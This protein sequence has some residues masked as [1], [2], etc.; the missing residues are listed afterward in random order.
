MRRLIDFGVL[1]LCAAI[2]AGCATSNET[3]GRVFA[4][5]A[6]FQ[7]YDCAQLR[8]FV[9]GGENNLRQLE[10]LKERAK[11]G[12]LGGVIATATYDPE[13]YATIG[14]L[15]GARL[16]MRELNCPPIK[17]AVPAAAPA[18]TTIKR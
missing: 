15:R 2:L 4:D 16:K 5:P 11:Q 7:L 18:Q 3:V 12:P 17:P 13:Y 1:G 6:K 10:R 9:N 8:N 14:D